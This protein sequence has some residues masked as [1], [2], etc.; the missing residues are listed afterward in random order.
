MLTHRDFSLSHFLSEDALD[1]PS[2]I[3]WNQMRLH[4]HCCSLL[5]TWFHREQTCGTCTSKTRGTKAPAHDGLTL[6]WCFLLLQVSKR[7][8]VIVHVCIIVDLHES[9]SPWVLSYV[10]KCQSH[11][12]YRRGWG[13]LWVFVKGCLITHWTIPM[14]YALRIWRAEDCVIIDFSVRCTPCIWYHIFKIPRLV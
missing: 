7:C 5:S 8:H 6:W 11:C 1:G 3:S 10:E 14:D 9:L 4:H 12:R 13:Y 2:R